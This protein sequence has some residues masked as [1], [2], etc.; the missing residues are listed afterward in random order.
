[1]NQA[2][3]LWILRSAAGMGSPGRIYQHEG[4]DVA[5]ERVH[6]QTAPVRVRGHRASHRQ[7]ISAGLLLRDSPG[8]AITALQPKITVNQFWPLDPSLNL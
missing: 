2:E 4:F 8:L 3:Q 1:V 6:L 7:A 5:D